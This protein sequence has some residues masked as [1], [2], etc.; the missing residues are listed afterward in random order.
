MIGQYQI[1]YLND[2]G[3]EQELFLEWDFVPGKEHVDE[4]IIETLGYMPET[5]TLYNNLSDLG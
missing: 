5:V 4:K 2:T 3:T 1:K